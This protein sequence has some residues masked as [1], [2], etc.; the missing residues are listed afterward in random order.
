[1]PSNDGSQELPASFS[2]ASLKDSL[3]QMHAGDLVPAL[4]LEEQDQIADG[5]PYCFRCGRPASSF[6]EYGDFIGTDGF[7]AGDRAAYV[8]NE[9]GTYN[10]AT[11]RF[12]CDGCYIAIG[13]PTSPS[14]WKAP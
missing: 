14:G 5:E 8:R 13:Q 4:T 3:R 12:C 1:M 10:P 6:S 7:I 2:L 11:N 9:E